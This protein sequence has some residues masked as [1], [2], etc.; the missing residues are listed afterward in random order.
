MSPNL[1]LFCDEKKY[2]WDGSVYGTQEEASAVEATYEKDN[3]EVHVIEEDG[4]FL[5]Y[6]RKF[7]KEV[8]VAAQ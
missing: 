3:F 2:M 4:K 7:V 5:V 6:T 8:V 1:S